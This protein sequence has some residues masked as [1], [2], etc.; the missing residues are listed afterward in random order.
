MQSGT[1][2]LALF[3]TYFLLDLC[4]AYSSTLGMETVCSTEMSLN[5]PHNIY[6]YISENILINM[7]QIMPTSVYTIG[8]S[9]TKGRLNAETQHRRARTCHVSAICDIQLVLP[10]NLSLHETHEP[11]ISY[12]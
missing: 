9:M 8:V 1:L 10:Q 7:T 3:A 4:F 11:K 6:H 12:K 2:F 5:F